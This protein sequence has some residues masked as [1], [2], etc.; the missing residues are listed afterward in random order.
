MNKKQLIGLIVAGVVF[1]FVC[2]SSIL[3]NTVSKKLGSSLN[4]SNIENS[5]PL[6]PY[7]GV[8]SVEGT[9]ADSDS[10]ASFMGSGY[11]HKET[12]ELI[13]DM[14]NSS[15]N[16]GILLYVDSPGGGVYESDELYL[17]L[18]EYKEETGRPVWTY[19]SN[20]ACSGGYYI[21][22]ASDKVYSNRNTWTGSIGV[23]ISLTNL[24]ELYD[25]IG[26]KGI[27]ITS[28][29]NKAMGAAD[30]D[31]TDEQRDILQSLVD[32]AYEQFVEIVAEGRKMT[33]DEVKK[34]AD[35]RILSA[36]QALELNLIDEIATY[37]EVK[38]AFSTELG[39]VEV[40]TPEKN[41]PF[42]LSSLF[43]YISSLRP[44]SD[45]EIISE[46]IKANGNGVPMYYAMPGQY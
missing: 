9:I 32:E 15:S 43:G 20:Q 38:E 28:G 2:S 40:Y 42:G 18:K 8:I 25:N 14:K 1:V 10:T 12:L 31:L 39:D 27:Y 45:A 4:L 17:K 13:E 24:K 19:M 29:K 3:M 21:S 34:I 16:K 5:L 36:K 30:L 37:E 7:I 22:M 35:G 6:S 44:R 33:V 11:N 46:L 23:I 41:D 26:I